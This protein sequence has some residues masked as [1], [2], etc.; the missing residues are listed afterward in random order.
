MLRIL[1]YYNNIIKLLSNLIVGYVSF[2][3]FLKISIF[4][5]IVACPFDKWLINF[6]LDWS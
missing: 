2:F 3:F 6:K 1:F 5:I 4:Y